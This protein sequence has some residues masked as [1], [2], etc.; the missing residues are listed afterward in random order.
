MFQIARRFSH[1][2]HRCYDELT[3]HH[4]GVMAPNKRPFTGK[5]RKPIYLENA[6]PRDLR[7]ALALP[8]DRGDQ[9]AHVMSEMLE[10][11][12]ELDNFFGLRPDA[13]DILE[14]RGKAL[15]SR[16]F[17]VP[18]EASD[19]W[20]QYTFY[21][22]RKHVPGFAV[23]QTGEQRLGAPRRW[24][25][26]RLAQLFADVEY[27][28]KISG[29]SARECCKTLSKDRKYSTRWKN[30][31]CDVLRNAYSQANRRRRTFPFNFEL[32]GPDATI[33]ANGIDPIE[34]AIERHALKP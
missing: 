24:T 20:A 12:S 27:L 26:E 8:P 33:P 15:I 28:K 7:A 19:W 21:L 25:T 1:T 14:Q 3:T 13:P 10:R 6:K 5:L 17:N 29:R 30:L 31:S 23:K 9:A 32:Y 22:L 34:A 2:Q 16:L 11:L 18:A 4:E